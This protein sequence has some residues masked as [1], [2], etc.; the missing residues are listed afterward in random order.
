MSKVICEICGTAYPDTARECP[1]CGFPRN[2]LEAELD[3]EIEQEQADTPGAAA[4]AGHVKGGRFSNRNVK[5]RLIDEQTPPESGVHEPEMPPMPPRRKKSRWGLKLLAVVLAVAVL[6]AGAYMAYR[7]VS[8][9]P[10][11]AVSTTVPPVPCEDVTLSTETVTLRSAGGEYLLTVIPAPRDTTDRPSFVSGDEAVATVSSQ[12]VIRAIGPGSTVITVICGNVTKECAITCEFEA[13]VVPGETGAAAE[14]TTAPS[15]PEESGTLKLSH[16]DV[17][18]FKAGETFQIKA[19]DAGQVLS[20]VQLQWVSSDPEVATVENGLVTAVHTGHAT[21]TAI[22][23]GYAAEC[24]VRVSIPGQEAREPTRPDHYADTNW[25]LTPSG[26]DVT[27]KVGETFK[28]AVVNDAGEAA[29]TAWAA[30][31]AG[32]VTIDGN[33][34]EG[35]VRGITE[36]TATVDGKTF[37]CIVRVN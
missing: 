6:T 29:E 34:I 20:K 16:S 9:D 2:P 3:L 24:L 26:G 33:R 27:I 18:L 13:P 12:G 8:G 10:D 30:S 31:D 32:I 14:A 7:Y 11:G 23:N 17:T 37:T 21:I 5:Q 28:L 15:I 4:S 25:R 1:I 36:V 35:A 22:Y 19:T